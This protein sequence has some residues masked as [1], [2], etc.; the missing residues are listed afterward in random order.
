MTA[1]YGLEGDPVHVDFRKWPDR[2]HWQLTMRRLGTDEHGLWLWAPPGTVAQRG[3]EPPTAFKS[4][5]VKLITADRWWTAIWNQAGPFELY[6]DISTPASWDGDRVTFIDLDLDVARYRD[7]GDV[8]ILDED[9]FLDHQ[10]RY[11]YPPNII[12]KARSATA[13]VAIDVEGR[14]EPFGDVAAAWLNR[15]IALAERGGPS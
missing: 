14:R 7:T 2:L 6:V 3:H 9:E 10:V 11:N 13:Q 12:D 15:A 4:T 1:T 5:A 8:A